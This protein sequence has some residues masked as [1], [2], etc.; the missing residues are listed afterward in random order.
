[1][2]QECCCNRDKNKTLKKISDNELK[3]ELKET[4]RYRNQ[5]ASFFIV[6]TGVTIATV[7]V[8]ATGGTATLLLSG[9]ITV[10][11]A[12][13]YIYE[14]FVQNEEIDE[15]KRELKRREEAEISV[16]NINSIPISKAKIIRF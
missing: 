2:G 12:I 15:I 9:I 3:N 7:I 13:Y 1:M 16:V 14:V 6:Y 11:G 8:V 5:N 4:R 10:A